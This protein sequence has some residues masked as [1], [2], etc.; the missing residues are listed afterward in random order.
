MYLF[1]FFTIIILIIIYYFYLSSIDW[2]IHKNI[3]HNDNSI[4]KSWRRK[5][6]IHHKEFNNEI[7][8][9]NNY[10]EFSFSESII[11]G[12]VSGIVIFFLLLFFYFKYKF[13]IKYIFYAFILHIIFIVIGA[14]IH[15]YSHSLF[16]KSTGIS[17]C[18]RIQ[19]P[20]FFINILHEHH[21]QHHNNCKKN[22][23]TVFLGFDNI[24]GTNY[25]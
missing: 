23:C 25:K 12:I 24:I 3:M 6:I 18:Y 11:I 10:I 16:H 19:I 15:N 5:H 22:F 4:L 8:Q 17:D 9:T 7:K 2:F 21:L 1:K 13:N 20:Q 14:S